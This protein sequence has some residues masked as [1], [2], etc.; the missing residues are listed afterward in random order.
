MRGFA[1]VGI[2]GGAPVNFVTLDGQEARAKMVTSYVTIHVRAGLV[3]ACA[4]LLVTASLTADA[5]QVG[6][7]ARVATLWTT[8]REIAQPYLDT[9][10]D[11]LRELGWVSGRNLSLENRFTDGKPESLAGLAAEL[12]AWKPDVVVAPLNPA[13]LALKRLTST[14]PIVFIVAF[15]PVET[16]LAASLAH[17]GSNA[18]GMTAAGPE[19]AAKRLQMLRELAPDARRVGVIGNAAFPGYREVRKA[20]DD[21]ALGLGFTIVEGGIHSPD[22]LPRML[23]TMARERIHALLV[24]GDN[25]THLHLREIVAAAAYNRW[26]SIYSQREFCDSG[27]LACYGVHLRANYK[28]SAVFIDQILRG[29]SPATIPIE[30]PTTYSL[31]LNLRTA[32]LLGINVPQSLRMRA[33][34]LI[35]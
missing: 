5:Q 34:Q 18:T 30:A 22:G 28:R 26:P 13:V 35:E 20:L 6:K 11:G 2:G 21:A 8:S 7:I 10:E 9:I 24:L 23:Q 15:D 19:T 27:G 1:F 12:V 32:K 16:G 25:L 29:A 33:D 17:P 3:L 14:I 31:L 4:L